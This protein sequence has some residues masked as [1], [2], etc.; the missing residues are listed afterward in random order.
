MAPAIIV[1]LL[2][3][4]A[5]GD[6]RH[7]ADPELRGLATLPRDIRVHID[8]RIN[9]DHWAGEEPYDRARRREIESAVRGLRCDTL[10]REERDLRHRYAPSPAMLKMIDKYPRVRD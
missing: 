2:L 7:D 9:C 1:A 8:R 6:F 5:L 3:G 10:D 4:P